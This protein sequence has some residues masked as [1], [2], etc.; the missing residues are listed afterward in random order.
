MAGNSQRRG[1]MRNPGSKKGATVGSGGQRRKQLKGK[2]P[3]PKATERPYHQAAKR[4]RAAERSDVRTSRTSTG[5]RPAKREDASMLMGRNSVVEGLRAGVPGKCLYMQTRVEADDRWRESLRRALASNIPV[6]E[7]TKLELDRM[8]DGGVHQG[9]VLTVPAYEY[10]ELDEFLDSTLIVALDGVT[11]TRNLG[12]VARS[13]AA[14]GAGGIVVPAR[15]SAGVSAGAWKTSAGALSRV[16]V[17]QVTNLTRALKDLQQAGFTV[18]GL[19][20]D[21]EHSLAELPEHVFTEPVVIVIGSEGKGLSR[22]VA[23]TCDWKVRIEMVKGNESLNASVAAGI[24]LHAV[25][26]AR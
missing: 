23:E 10:A 24:A 25:S 26:S 5:R 22:L 15:R 1:A 12:A 17:A 19:A 11:D 2:G 6:L 9:L 13:A 3:T 20:A 7:V 8:T 21:A 4:Q 18:V 14:F 16:D